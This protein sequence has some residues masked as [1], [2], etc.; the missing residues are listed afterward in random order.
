MRG[1]HTGRRIAVRRTGLFRNARHMKFC[2]AVFALYDSTQQL[3]IDQVFFPTACTN[4]LYLH[5]IV[6]SMRVLVLTNCPCLK[7]VRQLQSW[8]PQ[9]HFII[10]ES[11]SILEQVFC[12]PG[13]GY[14]SCRTLGFPAPI[15]NIT[16]FVHR[17]R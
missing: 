14:V 7:R 6:A 12:R 9:A 17:R 2:V 4:R 13:A 1:H 15:L 16:L 5:S 8:N 11:K 3:R 10:L